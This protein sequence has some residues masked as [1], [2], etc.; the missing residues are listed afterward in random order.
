MPEYLIAR[1]EDHV[2]L[3]IELSGFT[4][5]GEFRDG[6][7]EWRAAAGAGRLVVTFPPQHLAEETSPSGTPAPYTRPAG[8]GVVPVWRAALSGPSRVVIVLPQGSVVVPTVEGLLRALTQ[9]TVDAATAV[10]LPWRLIV[11]PQGGGD[12]QRVWSS[13]TRC[14]SGSNRSRTR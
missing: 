13:P 14:S 12:G 4:P 3:G 5:T 11:R 2:L 9:G 7:P 10:E 1:A 8:T 6:V